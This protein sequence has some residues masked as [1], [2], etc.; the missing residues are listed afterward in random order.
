MIHKDFPAQNSF[1]SVNSNGN[2]LDSVHFSCLFSQKRGY[3]NIVKYIVRLVLL[4]TCALM[5]VS[6]NWMLGSYCFI[7]LM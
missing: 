1:N 3:P 7:S 5:F 6:Y 4:H 2:L